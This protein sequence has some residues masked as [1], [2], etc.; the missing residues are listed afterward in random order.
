[1]GSIFLRDLLGKNPHF[2]KIPPKSPQEEIFNLN[3]LEALLSKQN[4]QNFLEYFG[5][6]YVLL[7]WFGFD[8]IWW[9]KTC[10]GTNK[11]P[12]SYYLFL[13]VNI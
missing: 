5:I 2:L 6:L 12:D 11:D 3:H 1:M 4:I 8:L 7:E 10:V 9:F 13:Q